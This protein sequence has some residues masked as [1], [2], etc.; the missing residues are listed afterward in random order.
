MRFVFSFTHSLTISVISYEHWR[1]PSRSKT[2]RLQP[3][4]KLIKIGAK[5]VGHRRYVAFQVAHVAIP[6][7]L[8][9]DILRLIAD[10]R[11]PAYPRSR[12]VIGCHAFERNPKERCIWM[13]TS[14]AFPH[15][16][17][18]CHG[19]GAREPRVETK[20]RRK[21]QLHLRQGCHPLDVG[22]NAAQSTSSNSKNNMQV[23]GKARLFERKLQMATTSGGVRRVR[24][25]D[26]HKYWNSSTNVFG[27]FF[28]SKVIERSCAGSATARKV[29]LTAARRRGQW[30]SNL[31][32]RLV[33]QE[34]FELGSN[35]R[36]FQRV[37]E[38]HF[39]RDR[40]FRGQERL[41]A[42]A[43]HSYPRNQQADL[44]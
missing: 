12:E 4:K 17:R 19:M 6:R 14:W 3:R 26:R 2:G 16:A 35:F 43:K 20:I 24:V 1:R 33:Q 40:L 7:T 36:A 15:S 39:S 9:G 21:W 13:T 30:L 32:L 38:S 18:Q 37:P 5:V 23:T 34:Y 27:F 11:P 31:Y 42:P 10:L 8:F 41:L 25:A 44:H 29:T 28:H 22:P